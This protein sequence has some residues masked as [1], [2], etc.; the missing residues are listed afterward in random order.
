MTL[1]RITIY[2]PIV[3]VNLRSAGDDDEADGEADEG[4][5][6]AGDGSLGNLGANRREFRE[7]KRGRGGGGRAAGAGDELGGAGGDKWG[8]GRETGIVS[9]GVVFWCGWRLMELMANLIYPAIR[10]RRKRGDR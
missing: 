10:V 7:G 1:T 5:G 3:R 2:V 6:E 9:V 4:D 8:E